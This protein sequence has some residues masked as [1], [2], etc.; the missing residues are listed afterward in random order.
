MS[1]LKFVDTHNMI[2]FLQ[3]PAES[4][5]FEQIV[6]FL[7]AHPI[8]YALTINPKIYV[9]PITQFW[10]TTKLKTSNEEWHI[11]AKVD[12]RKVILTESSLR[13]VLQLGDEDG[14]DCLFNPTIFENLALMGYEKLFKKLTFYKSS[15]SQ[16]WKFL[17]HTILQCLSSKTT[18]WNEFGIVVA[19]SII[20]LAIK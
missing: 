12:G 14:I 6:D 17:I 15:F 16:Q 19:S 20:C 5:G 8:M 2:A 9:S 13:E 10:A 3:K 4:E 1:D 7:V 11:H 18:A